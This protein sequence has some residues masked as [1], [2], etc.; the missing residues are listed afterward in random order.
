AARPKFDDSELR[1]AIGACINEVGSLRA[2]YIEWQADLNLA[3]AEGIKNVER[4]ENRIRATVRRAREQLADVGLESPG[5]E[6]EYRDLQDV[7]GARRAAP[8]MPPVYQSMAGAGN[9]FD[10]IPGDWSGFPGE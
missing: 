3:V 6:A 7:N 8:P 1:E 2:E 5:L 4:A 10:G 9:R